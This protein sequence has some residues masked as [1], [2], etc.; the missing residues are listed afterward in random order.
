VD[1]IHVIALQHIHGHVVEVLSDRRDARTDAYV[2]R[3]QGLRR[4]IPIS[5]DPIAVGVV[6]VLGIDALGWRRAA[7]PA[8]EGVQPGM[9]LQ[10]PLMS[11]VDGI[12]KGIPARICAQAVGPVASELPS[13][14]L[15]VRLIVGISMSP[16]LKDDDVEM[17]LRSGHC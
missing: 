9:E 14:G 4:T 10:A 17:P 3:V 5:A 12:L 15:V 8:G 11:L 1:A 16:D 6:D 7:P 13:P 2:I